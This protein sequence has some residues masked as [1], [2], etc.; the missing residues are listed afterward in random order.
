MSL[1]P[2]DHQ[3]DAVKLTGD[4]K[5]DL[6]EI[7]CLDGMKFFLKNS[8]TVTYNSVTYEGVALQFGGSRRTSKEE[9]P[10]PSLTLVNPE[11]VLSQYVL[12]ELFDFGK[13]VRR[14]LLRA[15]LDGNTGAPYEEKYF[16]ARA[17][18]LTKRSV[19]FELRGYSDRFNA[20][21][22]ARMYILPDFPMVSLQ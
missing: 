8:D 16:I 7:V 4:G 1:P 10:R 11:G 17:T 5:V 22:P 3:W 19:T 2:T 14:Q 12:D 6:F 15:E 20:N 9:T 13:V 18:S 21:I